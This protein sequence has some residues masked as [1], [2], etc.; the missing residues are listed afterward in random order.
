MPRV[1]LLLPAAGYRNEDFL[2]AAQK[3]GVEVVAAADYCHR[4]APLMGMSP[5]FSLPFDQPEIAL[6]QAL[7]SLGRRVD[8]VLAVDDHG[9]ELAALLR[10]KLGLPGNPLQAVRAT[11]D[12]LAF[13]RLLQSG[14]LNCPDFYHLGNGAPAATLLPPLQFPVV[15]KARR[16]SASRGVIRAD[17]PQAY[18]QA[19]QWVRGIQVKADRDAAKLGLVVE[20]FIPG[21]EYALEGLLENG[22]LR[23]LALFDKP[24]PLDGPYFEETLY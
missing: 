14:G 2:S 24:D 12:K 5:I 6:Q 4:L 19:V 21:R 8:A 3:L 23:V 13:R 16:L 20:S 22:E 9:L 1:L 15:V 7:V 18:T 17:T 11:R 10:D